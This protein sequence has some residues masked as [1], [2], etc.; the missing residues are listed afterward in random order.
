MPRNAKPSR[1]RW[2]RATDAGL[3]G[4]AGLL[5]LLAAVPAAASRAP[6]RPSAPV[7][8]APAGQAPTVSAQDME[9]AVAAV[10]VVALTEQFDGEPVSIAIDG[11][12]TSVAGAR[13][14]VVTGT[15]TV[16]PE[17]GREPIGFSYRTVFDVV[18]GN[19]AYPTIAIRQV[20]TGTERSVPNDAALVGQLDERVASTL[21]GELGGRRVWLQFDSIRSHESG[22]RYVRIDA[23]GIADFGPDGRTPTRV[24][25][26]YDR[27][28][29]RWL[30]V[31]YRLGEEAGA[32]GEPFP[33]G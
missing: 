23:A 17:G 22:G 7:I 24:E 1:H 29:A 12:R 6:S 10:V 33:G 31:N 19:A 11:Y 28:L 20:G 8:A 25:G 18:A 14:R 9:D 13:E 27:D 26:L 5:V 32:A 30:R 4:L 16:T 21:S 15:G 2:A 3:T